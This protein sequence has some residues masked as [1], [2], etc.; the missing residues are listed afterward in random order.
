M[1]SNV[2]QEKIQMVLEKVELLLFKIFMSKYQILKEYNINLMNV[3]NI[4][5]SGVTNNIQLD[6]LGKYLFGKLFLGTF[7]SDFFPKHIKNGN[8]FIMNNKASN[9]NGEHFTAFYKFGN[10]LYGH[11]SFNRTVKSLSKYW[12]N[13]HIVNANM[14]PEQSFKEKKLWKSLNGMA[15]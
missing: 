3:M 9:Q 13:K 5:G 14:D 7:S 8:C 11:D 10:K 15:R 12:W 1:E 4:L 2:S 6:K